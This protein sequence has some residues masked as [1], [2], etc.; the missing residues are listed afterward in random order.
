MQDDESAISHTRLAYLPALEDSPAVRLRH[1][2]RFCRRPSEFNGLNDINCHSI[3]N[4]THTYCF[5]RHITHPAEARRSRSGR[6]P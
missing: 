4:N 3:A 2:A 6:R 5:I 1:P